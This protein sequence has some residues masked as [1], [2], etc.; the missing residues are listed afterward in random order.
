MSKNIVDTL[1]EFSNKYNI[2]VVFIPSRRQIEYNGGYVNNWTTKEFCE[3]VKKGN[4]NILIE[5]DHGGPGQGYLDDDGYESLS[6]DI[7]YM[8]IIH[9]DPWKK[10]PNYNDGL[11]WTIEMIQY[12][13]E[14]NSNLYFEVGTEEGIRPFTPNELEQ[15][16]YDLKTILSEE[17]FLRI[18][19]A[20]IQC[21]TKLLEKSNI[22]IFDANRLKEMLEVVKKFNLEAKEHNGDWV[23][24]D[25]IHIKESLGL[26]NINI[27]P[28]FG[29]IETRVL[30]NTIDIEDKEIFFNI[31][32]ESGK[33]KK[34]VQSSFDPYNNKNLLSLICGHYIFSDQKI[35]EMKE[36]YENLDIIIKKKL[37]NTFFELNSLYS[38]RSKCIF[39][40]SN[41]IIEHYKTDLQ[42]PISYSMIEKEI[43]YIFIP[44]NIQHCKECF[45]FQ[46]KYLGNINEVYKVNHIDNFGSV[47]HNMH[48]AFCNF[49]IE[50]KNI[51][52]II[53][54]G[55]SHDYLARLIQ[56]ENDSIQ[57]N[58]INPFF[59][60][61]PDGLN[62]ISNYLETTD[63]SLINANTI[64]MSN[65]FEHFYNPLY[66]LK[67]LKENTNIKYIYINHPDFDYAIEN[68][69]YVNLTVEHTFY[70][71]NNYLINLFNNYGFKLMKKE[72]FENH[73]VMFGFE[74]LPCETLTLQNKLLG[75][76]V[77]QY[78]ERLQTKV[79]F[80]N[81]IIEN[82][83]DKIIYAWP[84]SM[85]LVPLFIN[86]LKYSNLNG[87]LDNS[88]NKINKIFYGYNLLCSNFKE[89]L[90]LSDSRTI[91]F[92][93]GSSN[94]RKELILSNSNINFYEI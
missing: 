66:V 7:N 53:G 34:W 13:Y 75:K 54:I 90:D 26:K 23:T 62:I 18:K 79:T 88:P 36:R 9:I 91:F 71:E 78:L 10:Y 42:S 29:E 32:L 5:R 94:Y 92:L 70:F 51:N 15:F 82:N 84:S 16:L 89:V 2:E 33:W 43:S 81:A 4:K 46:T 83:K 30:L 1:I 58:I 59:R 69:I 50:N 68:D 77:F 72:N 87:L 86:G 49:I 61:N 60:G 80:M 64:L 73:T 28:E 24:K 14:R 65:V 67:I 8:D 40:E 22:G 11:K 48:S 85:H 21:G 76:N 39:C 74:R 38:I 93:G 41:N 31:C 12:C 35:I 56:K 57:Y 55:S 20:V 25:T 52:N 27:A 19:Y 17:I 45:S 44:Y 6:E 37:M 3:Y 47:K 63:L